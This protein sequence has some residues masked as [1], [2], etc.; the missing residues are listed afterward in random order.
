MN[1]LTLEQEA[2]LT[3]CYTHQ[4]AGSRD[5][6]TLGMSS[7][8]V[9]LRDMGMIRM[10][11]DMSQELVL[12]QGM[13]PAGAE[14]YD[15]ARKERRR[16]VAVDDSADEL[17]MALAVQDKAS[18]GSDKPRLVSTDL[19]SAD[20]YRDLEGAGLL[21]IRWAD[22]KPW[23]VSVTGM[24]RSYAEGW[25]LDQMNDGPQIV[26][27]PTFINSPTFNNENSSSANASAEANVAVTLGV[28][29]EAI[30]GLDD[31]DNATKNAAQK[32]AIDLDAAAKGKNKKAFAEKLEGVA[33]VIKSSAT[34][35]GVVLP[36][37]Q[38]AIGGFLG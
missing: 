2:A 23:T 12:Y 27:N 38:N 29:I 3:I 24:G 17:M 31:V 33:S 26:N 11:T 10:T 21:N 4:N 5:F 13:L 16:F 8:F 22:D 34:L 36:F 30:A 37:I 28:T 9:A 15:K 1:G 14:H 32:A 7:A 25:F 19:S 18:K 20:D 35:A 6:S